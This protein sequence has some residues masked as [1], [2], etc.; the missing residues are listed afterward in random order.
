MLGEP[1]MV[2][3]LTYLKT[4]VHLIHTTH[5][6]VGDTVAQKIGFDS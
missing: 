3:A 4:K 2:F 5:G 1:L 6:V